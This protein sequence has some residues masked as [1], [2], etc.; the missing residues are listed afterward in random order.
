MTTLTT[1]Q[2]REN[3]PQV[4]SD[5][6]HGKPIQLT[7]RHK[8]I[9]ILQPV[10]AV[11]HPFRRGSPEAILSALQSVDFGDAATPLRQSTKSFKEEIR[12]LRER[13]L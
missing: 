13:D 4:I 10:G 5:L 1:K 2:L 12:E 9:G 6:Q 7:Y 11:S 3:M 8:I